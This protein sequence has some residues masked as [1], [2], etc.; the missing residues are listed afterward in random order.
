MRV[1]ELD[2][3]HQ[4]K[5]MTKL[6]LTS[7]VDDEIDVSSDDGEDDGFNFGSSSVLSSKQVNV[8]EDDDSGDDDSEDDDSEDDD[9]EDDDSED[10]EDKARFNVE[11]EYSK[12]G[13]ARNNKTFKKSATNAKDTKGGKSNK[14]RGIDMDF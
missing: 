6:D 4:I 7:Q 13:S 14:G 9:S 8:V 3:F 12:G 11:F 1:F 2:T 10:E 5:N